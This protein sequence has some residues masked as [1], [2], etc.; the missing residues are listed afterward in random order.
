M[1]SILFWSIT[2]ILLLF[3]LTACGVTQTRDTT[4]EPATGLEI[5]GPALILF[6]TDN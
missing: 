4:S 1:K 3:G 2:S 6:Y 5:E